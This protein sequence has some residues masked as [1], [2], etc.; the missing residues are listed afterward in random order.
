LRGGGRDRKRRR[1]VQIAPTF[2]LTQSLSGGL[3][4]K[5]ALCEN[6]L[7]ACCVVCLVELCHIHFGHSRCHEHNPYYDWQLCP[8]QDCHQTRRLVLG[9]L[10]NEDDA[11]AAAAVSMGASAAAASA[12]SSE[13]SEEDDVPEVVPDS[14]VEDEKTPDLGLSEGPSASAEVADVFVA[15]AVS[16]VLELLEPQVAQDTSG[17]RTPPPAPPPPPQ[18][19]LP[20]DGGGEDAKMWSRL[21]PE[22]LWIP[23]ALHIIHSASEN[24]TVALTDFK[25]RYLPQLRT[26]VICLDMADMRR[27]FVATCLTSP[28]AAIFAELFHN[29]CPNLQEWRWGSLMDCVGTIVARMLPLRL[30]WKD[31]AMSYKENAGEASGGRR[32][33]AAAE[34]DAEKME[35]IA[36]IGAVIR[37]PYFW[38]YSHMLAMLGEVL[39][40]LQAYFLSCKCH[41]RYDLYRGHLPLRQ[42]AERRKASKLVCPMMGRL[43]P[44]MAVGEWKN[45]L[46]NLMA[47]GT[48]EV[49]PHT[50][51]LDQEQRGRLLRE[52]DASKERVVTSIRTCCETK[53]S[54]VFWLAWG[55]PAQ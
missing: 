17:L 2:G 55:V 40:E 50:V 48:A 52:F 46:N 23:G 29:G 42:I 20:E 39:Q 8:C 26:L 43:A 37:D 36:K 10:N 47:L 6:E 49:L 32:P 4:A 38:A 44:E 41:R 18:P 19:P 14:D 11:A 33:E 21:F 7:W 5:C 1:I 30:Y 27:R 22:C 31:Q 16:A 3:A 45:V 51:G 15:A 12:V 28:E 54:Y 13:D 35:S 25:L 53:H 9:Q 24:L 34:A